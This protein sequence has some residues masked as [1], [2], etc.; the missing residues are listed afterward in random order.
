MN[1]SIRFEQAS[2]IYDEFHKIQQYEFQFLEILRLFQ[3]NPFM[4]LT[5]WEMFEKILELAEPVY[6]KD[7]SNFLFK[8]LD[9]LFLEVEE[10]QNNPKF[11]QMQQNILEMIKK[12]NERN[13]EIK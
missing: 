12:C 8:K 2:L 5:A 6:E 1:N 7:W 10:Y 11:S 4:Q 9:E 3:K 13:I